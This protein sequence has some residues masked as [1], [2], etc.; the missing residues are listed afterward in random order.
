[1]RRLIAIAA[2]F[3]LSTQLSKMVLNPWN[4]ADRPVMDLTRRCSPTPVPL[5]S[6]REP[7]ILFQQEHVANPCG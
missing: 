5:R 1:M 7:S 4:E 6:P 3:L 2:L